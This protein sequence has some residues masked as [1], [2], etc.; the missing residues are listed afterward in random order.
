MST[1]ELVIDETGSSTP[2]KEKSVFNSIRKEFGTLDLLS[3]F[4][5]DRY[6]GAVPEGGRRVYVDKKDGSSEEIGFTHSYWNSDISHLPV[7]KWHQTDWIS[8]SEITR[9]P[10]TGWR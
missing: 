7:N 3:A 1:F 10:V 6:G 9:K 8:V 2:A 4:L 5:A